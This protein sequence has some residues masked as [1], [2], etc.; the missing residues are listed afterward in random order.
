MECVPVPDWKVGWEVSLIIEALK[1][2]YPLAALENLVSTCDK[3]FNLYKSMR[4]TITV[5]QNNIALTRKQLSEKL[6]S[7]LADFGDMPAD[8]EALL[9][10]KFEK[11]L[12]NFHNP[13]SSNRLFQSDLKEAP[14]RPS[15]NC[16]VCWLPSNSS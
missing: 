6:I 3:W 14:I 5:D 7:V 9:L 12:T 8:S 1:E 2:C 11:L 10:S 4:K 16:R 15:L 13:H